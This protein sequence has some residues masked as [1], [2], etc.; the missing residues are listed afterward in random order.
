[1]GITA[2]RRDG[3]RSNLE[4]GGA[5]SS[6]SF[7]L[8]PLSSVASGAVRGFARV[9]GGESWESWTALGSFW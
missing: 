2:L 6:A 4:D 9:S 5:L 7:R 8:D 3:R 1:M